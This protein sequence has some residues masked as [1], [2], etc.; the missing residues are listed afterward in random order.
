MRRTFEVVYNQNSLRL[1]LGETLEVMDELKPGI[2]DLCITRPPTI[3]QQPLAYKSFIYAVY[4]AVDR[5]LSPGGYFVVNFT[6][7]HTDCSML[8]M[9]ALHSSAGIA[10]CDLQLVGTRIVIKRHEN[11]SAPRYVRESSMHLIDYEYAWTWRKAGP[12]KDRTN[13]IK[14]STSGIIGE[15]WKQPVVLDKGSK[16][17]PIEFPLHMMRIYAKSSSKSLILDPF[18]GIGTTLLAAK[19]LG[20][21]C[22]GID[23]NQQ[24]LNFAKQR[25]EHPYQ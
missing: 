22:V 2:F 20:H 14:C 21:N 3:H 4:M 16:S 25:I 10:C 7:E 8:P 12:H 19:H 9:Q 17:F 18:V 1:L 11:H 23:N 24:H 15:G 13:N 5:L 6:D